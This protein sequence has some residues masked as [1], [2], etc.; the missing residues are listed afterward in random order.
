MNDITT[1]T[2]PKKRIAYIDAMRGLTMLLVVY[3]HIQVHGYK[4][5]L[6]GFDSFNFGSVFI[7]FRMPL[8]F[9]IS[10]WVLYKSSRIWDIKTSL[11][12]LR[13]KFKVQ[14]LST[15]VFYVLFVFLFDW[16]IQKSI[17][18]FK[19][20][21]WFTYTLFFYFMFYVFSVNLARWLN[22]KIKEDFIVV[23]I[24][25]IVHLMYLYAL[26]DTNQQRARVCQ[27]VG[28]TQWRFYIFFCFGTLVKKYYGAFINLT[29]KKWTM[30]LV[31]CSFFLLNMFRPYFTLPHLDIV[32][33]LLF[34][35]LGITI[36]LTVF[37]K[38]EKWFAEDRHISK[39]MQYI[40]RHTLDI[41]LLHYFFL[42]RNLQ[43]IGEFFKNHPNPT[44]E[45]F[46]SITLALMVVGVCLLTSKVLCTSPWLGE[47][48]FGKKS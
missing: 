35:F 46:I 42:P 40:G 19:A 21:Y 28:V 5:H 23:V 39:W 44:I 12:F 13:K 29:E 8:F 7:E 4:I 37:R 20:G 41:Y 34:G 18:T 26:A 33:F 15:I 22:Y 2:A 27:I 45:I 30:A 9:F 16:N 48:L 31:L 3:C 25:I 38:N 11:S 32:F 1:A 10:G 43:F 14:I 24:A 47:F 36:I 17:G 6:I